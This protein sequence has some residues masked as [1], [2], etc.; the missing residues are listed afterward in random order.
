ME[1][2]GVHTA[3]ADGGW[4]LLVVEQRG[5]ADVFLAGPMSKAMPV[6]YVEGSKYLAIHFQPGTYLRPVPASQV[7]DRTIPLPKVGDTGFRLGNTGLQIP[8][9]DDVEA[10][11]AQLVRRE[12]LLRD[13]VVAHALS[14]GQVLDLSARSV[15]RHFLRATGLTHASIRQIERAHRAAELLRQGTPILAVVDETGYSDQSHLTKSLKRF[16]GQTPARVLSASAP[17]V[18]S[19][20]PSPRPDRR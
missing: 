17:R 15:Q 8:T 16:I 4:D 13:S 3:V 1:S 10:L 20:S 5:T 6:P 14:R 12:L 9:Y 18:D 7:V 11:V 2:D 19:S